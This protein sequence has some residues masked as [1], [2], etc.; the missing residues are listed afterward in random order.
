MT[1]ATA[2]TLDVENDIDITI[3]DEDTSEFR[4]CPCC[5]NL[6]WSVWDMTSCPWCGAVTEHGDHE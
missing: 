4:V 5:D 6:V 2:L 1:S 3:E